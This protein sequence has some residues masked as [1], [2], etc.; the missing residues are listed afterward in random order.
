MRKQLAELIAKDRAALSPVAL[1]AG[2]ALG[3]G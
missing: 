1:A 3:L 2:K